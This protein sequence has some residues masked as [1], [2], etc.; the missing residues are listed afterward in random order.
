MLTD[1]LRAALLRLHGY[2]VDVVEFIDSAHTPRNLMLRARRTGAAPTD[3]DRWWQAYLRRF[4][5]E[6]T[7]RFAK[8]TLGW[9][10]PKIRSPQAADRWTWL[11]LAAHTQL[12]LARPLVADLRR[13][14]ERP[15]PPGKLRDEG[16][17]AES[18]S[19]MMRS[20]PSELQGK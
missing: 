18:W 8:Q 5:I 17:E 11:L 6:H 14:W 7:F 3:V 2:R 4:D 1:S 12:R 19:Q 20:S 13:P 10:A 16:S 9:T 15:A